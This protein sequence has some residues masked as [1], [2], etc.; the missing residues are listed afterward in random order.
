MHN[1]WHLVL[2]PSADGE[3]SDFMHWLTRTHTQRWHA[4]Y[5]DVGSGH[6]Y[7]GRFKSFPIQAD[8]HFLTVCRYVERN[9]LRANLCRAA[10]EWPW[11]SLFHRQQRDDFAADVLS[12]WPV[13]RPRLWLNHVHAAETEAE[14]AALRRSIA[15]GTPYGGAGWTER[16]ARR[17][18]LEIT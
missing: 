12:E 6:L 3:L 9:A 7:Q 5:Q 4:H 10:Q 13:P 17:L 14:L 18:D 1:H 11:S 15:R 8:D 16:I 2:W